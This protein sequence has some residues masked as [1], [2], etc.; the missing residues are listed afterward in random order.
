MSGPIVTPASMYVFI[1]AD[2][3]HA[4]LAELPLDAVLHDRVDLGELLRA[5]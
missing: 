4:A 2:D 3:R 5:C 1:G